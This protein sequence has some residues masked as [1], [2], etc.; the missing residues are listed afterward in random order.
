VPGVEV[1]SFSTG[2]YLI[3][4]KLGAGETVAEGLD[5]RKRDPSERI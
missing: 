2:R 3:V 4:H 1:T 5:P